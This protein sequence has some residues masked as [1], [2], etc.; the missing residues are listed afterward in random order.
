MPETA[1]PFPNRLLRRQEI[2]RQ[3]DQSLFSANLE[4]LYQSIPQSYMGSEFIRQ[5]LEAETAEETRHEILETRKMF[6]IDQR[7]Y[8]SII[9]KRKSSKAPNQVG[10]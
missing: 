2:A 4:D 7:E 9:A 10:N 1:P 6:D 3:I 8:I 5:L